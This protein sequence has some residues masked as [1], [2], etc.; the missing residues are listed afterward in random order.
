MNRIR[1]SSALPR[2]IHVTA[3]LL[4]ENVSLLT[5]GYHIPVLISLL[6]W[7]NAR[8]L[9]DRNKFQTMF[10]DSFNEYCRVF[11]PITRVRAFSGVWIKHCIGTLMPLAD[12]AMIIC[13]RRYLRT[14]IRDPPGEHPEDTNVHTQLCLRWNCRC[15]YAR[16]YSETTPTVPTHRDR[17]RLGS[18]ETT[19][20]AKVAIIMS[21]LR[22]ILSGIC[23][24]PL[25]TSHLAS[26][27][28]TIA[29]LLWR[30]LLFKQL[31]P[32]PYVVRA[33]YNNYAHYHAYQLDFFSSAQTR[34]PVT[35]V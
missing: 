23:H 31:N 33:C 5:A 1:R 10:P 28:I 3:A 21:Y 8:E 7:L 32:A 16:W 15:S 17:R 13:W 18:T 35:N 2:E 26:R 29:S 9:L 11:G 24:N 22:L 4:P 20:G 6:E 25:R 14:R 30:V 19:P 34:I 27:L 12:Y